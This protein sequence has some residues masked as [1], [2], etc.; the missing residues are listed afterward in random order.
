MCFKEHRRI[1]R[2]HS[3]PY[4]PLPTCMPWIRCCCRMQARRM[5]KLH[6]RL[7][8]S[9]LGRHREGQRICSVGTGGREGR[10]RGAAGR[11]GWDEPC[12]EREQ[13]ELVTAGS[14][15]SCPGARDEF[16]NSTAPSPASPPRSLPE[17]VP[18]FPPPQLSSRVLPQTFPLKIH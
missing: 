9:P 10:A 17:P 7:R 14:R 2:A 16:S 11:G 6:L 13:R 8:A 15:R 4:H 3:F 5:F 12:Q 18:A 1:P